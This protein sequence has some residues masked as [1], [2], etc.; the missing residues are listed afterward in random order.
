[1]TLSRHQC[2]FGKFKMIAPF[3]YIFD[4]NHRSPLPRTNR[5]IKA[6]NLHFSFFAGGYFRDSQWFC[7]TV[8]LLP[9]FTP[10]QYTSTIYITVTEP[11]MEYTC[12]VNKYVNDTN[13][14]DSDNDSMFGERPEQDARNVRDDREERTEQFLNK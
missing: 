9:V 10:V 6:Q 7:S 8:H 14:N 11:S 4:A 5:G 2:Q 12:T 1:M 13:N 3:K